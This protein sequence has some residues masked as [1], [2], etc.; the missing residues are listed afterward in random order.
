MS[1]SLTGNRPSPSCGGSQDRWPG[2]GALSAATVYGR[3]RMY[4]YDHYV[5]PMH[6]HSICSSKLVS[7]A[8]V[9][10]L[11]CVLLEEGKEATPYVCVRACELRVARIVVRILGSSRSK[12][13][14]H[15]CN[16]SPPLSRH[17]TLAARQPPVPC[18]GP[19]PCAD[20]SCSPRISS[21]HRRTPNGRRPTCSAA[22]RN[23]VATVT[24]SSPHTQLNVQRLLPTI[25][26][27]N[28]TYLPTPYVGYR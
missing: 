19:M 6:I 12:R 13:S 23:A 17:A 24:Q 11:H 3:P 16:A 18:S 8:G 20:S 2:L 4:S 21:C 27:V 1:P 5:A 15:V 14:T 28:L 7:G 26:P 10:S 9:S 22:S 25:Y